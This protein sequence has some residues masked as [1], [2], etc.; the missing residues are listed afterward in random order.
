MCVDTQEHS[1]TLPRLNNI[2]LKSG[3][4]I[5]D[6]YIGY[7]RIDLV[8]VPLSHT[9]RIYYPCILIVF[10]ETELYICISKLLCRYI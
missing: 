6:F 1:E 9:H 8:I 3:D 5:C 10:I 4:F 2:P 7:V